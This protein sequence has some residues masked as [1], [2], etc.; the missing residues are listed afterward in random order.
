MGERLAGLVAAR[1]GVAQRD[2]E[3]ALEDI[4]QRLDE[5]G[6]ERGQGGQVRRYHG[7]DVRRQHVQQTEKAFISSATSRHCVFYK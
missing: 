5:V 4:R 6:G 3:E 7:G 2:V 1:S